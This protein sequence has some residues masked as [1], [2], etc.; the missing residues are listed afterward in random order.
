[1]R[2]ERG[3]AHDDA[4]HRAP[5]S[6]GSAILGFDTATPDTVVALQIDG[7]EPL[8]LRHAPAPGERPGHATQLLALAGALLEQAGLG[9]S[10]LDRIGVGV[11]PGTFTGLRIGVATA[12]ALAQASGADLVPVS[13][14]RALAAATGHDGPVLAV[15]DA[16]R[17][18][19]FAAAYRGDAELVAPV[20]VRPEA[21]AGLVA[22]AS[23]P[24][25]PWLAVGD[26]ALAFRDQLE[27]AAVA[28]PADGNPCHRVSAVAICRLAAASAPVARDMLI[29]EYVRLPDAEEARRRQQR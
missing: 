9:F 28:V 25:A 24:G 23:E 12:R 11:G 18:E 6:A 20:A 8:E 17:G 5:E 15:L 26:G 29:P 4:A 22:G 1:M 16:R 10:D 2:P 27:P 21:L 3:S 14:L 7:E 19:A 13:T